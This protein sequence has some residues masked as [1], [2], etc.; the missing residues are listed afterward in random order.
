MVILKND[1]QS[2]NILYTGSSKMFP[3]YYGIR[4]E[5]FKASFNIHFTKCIEI[6]TCS[7]FIKNVF[8]IQNSIN[9]LYT[10]LHTIFRYITT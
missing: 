1:I 6:S 7:S 10:G 2:T 5:M 8:H 9:I 4:E 3:I